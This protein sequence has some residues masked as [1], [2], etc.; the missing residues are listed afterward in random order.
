MARYYP[1]RA[2]RLG[3]S[4]YAQIRC[5]VNALGRMQSCTVVMET[6]QDN[7]F[8]QAALKLS[9]LFSVPRRTAS[10]ATTAGRSV[11]IPIRFKLP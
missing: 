11:D 9:R 2:Q 3:L 5:V 4:G 1:E 7:A 8:G 6:P 10:G